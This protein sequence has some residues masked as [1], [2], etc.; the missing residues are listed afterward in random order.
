MKKKS[1][2][3]ALAIAMLIVL[4]GCSGVKENQDNKEESVEVQTFNNEEVVKEALEKF[5]RDKNL[6]LDSVLKVKTEMDNEKFEINMLSNIKIDNQGNIKKVYSEKKNEDGKNSSE[7][8]EVFLKKVDLGYKRYD[9]VSGK[10]VENPGDVNEELE[11]I[12]GLQ[13]LF[14]N[15]NTLLS[16]IEGAEYKIENGEV[17]LKGKIKLSEIGN[18]F[19]VDLKE[20]LSVEEEEF[21]KVP[22]SFELK[23]DSKTKELSRLTFDIKQLMKD[24]FKINLEKEE[25]MSAV[26]AKTMEVLL[27]TI[28]NSMEGE[29]SVTRKIDDISETKFD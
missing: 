29:A 26:E 14:S 3:M 2:I 8:E 9:I 23:V 6:E 13:G 18:K 27:E 12:T 21:S 20:M 28:V 5:I 17:I 16:T 1:R 22:V 11:T 15:A 7:Q 25:G 4:A 10:L 19:F 24:V